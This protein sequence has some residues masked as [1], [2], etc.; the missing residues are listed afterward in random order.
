MTSLSYVSCIF[1]CPYDGPTS[2]GAVLHCVRSLLEAGC[3]EVSLGD[4]I[5]VGTPGQTRE[6]LSFLLANGIRSS[7]IAGHFH[8][9]YGQALANAWEAYNCGLRV[10]DSS[11]AGLGGC[12][13]APGAR[14]NLSSED[15]V[16]MFEES[17]IDTGV[18]LGR[19]AEVGDWISSQL[20]LENGS[21][22]GVAVTAKAKMI[23]AKP[24]QGLALP[25]A[26][27]HWKE[28]RNSEGLVVLRD[29]KTA[30]VILDRPKNG[31]ALTASMITELT[32]FFHD[33]KND[34]SL[35]RVI[36]TANG[37]FFCTGMDLS[38]GSS[39]VGK[40]GGASSNQFNLLTN[41][42]NAIDDAPQVTIAGIN[43]PCFG[44]GVGLA[45]ACDIRI[46]SPKAAITL[47]ETK[48][49][50]AAATISKYVVREL[51]IPFSR[52][53]FLS[54]RTI[55]ASELKQQGVIALVAETPEALDQALDDYAYSLRQSA[56]GASAMSKELVKL[57]WS[58]AG[59]QGQEDGIK[60]IFEAMMRPGGESSKGLAAFQSGQR[61]ID[62][63]ASDTSQKAK[64]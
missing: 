18:D 30:K 35:S 60:Q 48:L 7:Q 49:G 12:P 43:G 37:R 9:T 45:L 3:Y 6:L 27:F 53:A 38:K 39:P 29:N 47:T 1:A 42:F 2:P 64:L 8:D 19:L 55:P 15:L 11:V 44:G 59:S 36:L 63:D 22:A 51:G 10:F 58:S 13:Y 28:V 17:G 23:G 26:Q 52:E 24:P 5:G 31:N 57:G 20:K 25:K 41:L 4:T 54:A 62:W 32:N 61:K 21:R 34:K 33:C 16:Y 40:G 14:G 56:P 50:L 46:A